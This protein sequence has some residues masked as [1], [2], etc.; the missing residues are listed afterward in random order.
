MPNGNSFDRNIPNVLKSEMEK[1]FFTWI[2]FYIE[3]WFVDRL[4][5]RPRSSFF[6]SALALY[7][8]GSLEAA[9]NRFGTFFCTVKNV[10]K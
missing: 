4:Q 9:Q 7:E 2:V 10:K 1:L 8:A 6:R 5:S 3:A